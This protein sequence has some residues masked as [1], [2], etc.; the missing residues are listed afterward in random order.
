MEFID[1]DTISV[2]S[3]PGV[4]SFQL[5]SPHN[6]SSTQVTITRVRVA[7]GVAQP[8][9]R[10]EVS[11]Q[12]WCAQSGA[13]LL[14]LEHERTRRFVAGDVVRFAAGDVHGLLNDGDEVFEYIAVTS[15]P[16]DFGYAYEKAES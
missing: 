4:Q 14:L 8:R 11:E 15:P 7:V 2:L 12:I 16:I 13:G 5:L 9:H 10:H 1:K 3:N 6:A